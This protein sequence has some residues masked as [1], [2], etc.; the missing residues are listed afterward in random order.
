MFQLRWATV[1]SA[2]AFVA[3]SWACNWCGRIALEG[4]VVAI[5]LPSLIYAVACWIR[6]QPIETRAGAWWAL[7]LGV[8]VLDMELF[9]PGRPLALGTGSHLLVLAG[10]SLLVLPLAVHTALPVVS[11]HALTRL[12]TPTPAATSH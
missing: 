4:A 7:Y 11:P 2:L 1:I 8:L 12:G 6:R 3:A 10:L 9:S 5:G